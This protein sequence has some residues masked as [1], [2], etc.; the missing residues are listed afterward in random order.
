MS[1]PTAGI[2]YAITGAA[3]LSQMVALAYSVYQMI[4]RPTFFRR[5]LAAQNVSMVVYAIGQVMSIERWTPALGAANVF[6]FYFAMT[7]YLLLMLHRFSVFQPILNYRPK[8]LHVILMVV[9]AIVLSASWLV[10]GINMTVMF[11]QGASGD[12]AYSAPL[13]TFGILIGSGFSSLLDMV[14]SAVIIVNLK[15]FRFSRSLET[16]AQ[17]ELQ[18]QV[19]VSYA[20]LAG[21]LVLD[22]LGVVF[23]MSNG[24]SQIFGTAAACVIPMHTALGTVYMEQIA[25]IAAAKPST[26][27]RGASST[28]AKASTNLGSG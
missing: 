20:C 6:L 3:V 4:K 11:A 16:D 25:R 7:P 9:T 27:R 17:H 19:W 22:V 18:R 12:E 8:N 28:K 23:F 13:Y 26:T 14:L 10:A 5:M 24:V 15:Q 2:R 1:D 21:I